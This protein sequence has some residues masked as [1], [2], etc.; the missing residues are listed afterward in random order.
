MADRFD[1]RETSG[2]RRRPAILLADP[3]LSADSALVQT[4]LHGDY[5]VLIASDIDTAAEHIMSS[6]IHFC[7][8]ELKFAEGTGIDILRM[9][10]I[11]HP[12]CRTVVHSAHCDIATAVSVTRAGAADVLPKPLSAEFVLAILMEKDMGSSLQLACVEGP[13]VVRDEHIRQTLLSCGANITR[14]ARRLSMHR[15][16]LQRMVEKSPSLR[17]LVR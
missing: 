8:T 3:S 10:S 4:L 11:R 14:T 15:R 12:R 7:I 1:E 13:N 17:A 2:G 5:Q 9:L 6:D 16:T